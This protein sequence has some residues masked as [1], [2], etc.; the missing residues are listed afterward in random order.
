MIKDYGTNLILFTCR[1]LRDFD[2]RKSEKIKGLEQLKRN[3][4]RFP[5]LSEMMMRWHRKNR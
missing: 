1:I 3:E 2:R 5:S 4:G